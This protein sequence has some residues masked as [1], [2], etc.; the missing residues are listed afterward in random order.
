MDGNET[1]SLGEQIA[2][3]DDELAKAKEDDMGTARITNLEER[4][5]ALE[6]KSEAKASEPIKE[7][8]EIKESVTEEAVEPEPP[9]IVPK[10]AHWYH[11]TPRWL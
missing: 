7:I 9:V 4:L 6:A 8:K 2:E 11:K 1:E 10:R 3:I 5:A